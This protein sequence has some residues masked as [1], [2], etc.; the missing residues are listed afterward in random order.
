MIKYSESLTAWLKFFTL[1]TPWVARVRRARSLFMTVALFCIL[2][3]ITWALTVCPSL[4]CLSFSM[5]DVPWRGRFGV[6]L[7]EG[8]KSLL[9]LM[10]GNSVLGPGVEE[11]EL[12]N[13]RLKKEWILVHEAF[14]VLAAVCYKFII[15]GIVYKFDR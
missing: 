1:I 14:K 11:K 7:V 9:G 2:F 8:M 15:G 5:L 10:V 4:C 6:G 3:I 13:K 12:G